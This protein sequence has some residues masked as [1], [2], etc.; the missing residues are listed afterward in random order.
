M[1][2]IDDLVG[3]Y[4]NKG[5][6]YLLSEPNIVQLY[7]LS[8]SPFPKM[9][10]HHR[11]STLC[12]QDGTCISM[13]GGDKGAT[14]FLPLEPVPLEYEYPSLILS[15]MIDAV[16]SIAALS[17]RPPLIHDY[18]NFTRREDCKPRLGCK[19]TDKYDLEVTEAGNSISLRYYKPI[20]CIPFLFSHRC[21][22]L[23]RRRVLIVP[24]ILIGFPGTYKSVVCLEGKCVLEYSPEEQVIALLE[25]RTVT[26]PART[27]TITWLNIVALLHNA[28]SLIE[29][30]ETSRPVL[31]V[32]GNALIIGAHVQRR[33]NREARIELLLWNASKLASSSSVHFNGY[34]I[35]R[36]K[37]VTARGSTELIPE[38]DR[39]RVALHGYGLGILVLNIR[40]IPLFIAR[41]D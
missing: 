35:I 26:H 37:I 12:G 16:K 5:I 38:Y 9:H 36:A 6:E 19:P 7:V 17:D 18:Y 29:G 32:K 21:V 14:A 28:Y 30:T 27:K 20:I 33:D 13:G 11:V 4:Q 31:W 25:G 2:I 39:V 3:N 40:K 10:Q 41:R 22:R 15:S 23:R 1:K 24:W 34:K 8:G